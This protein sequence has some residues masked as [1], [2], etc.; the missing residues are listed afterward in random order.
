[1][2]RVLARVNP[3]TSRRAVG[4]RL[5]LVF[6]TLAALGT[7]GSFGQQPVATP[8]EEH[9]AP[10]PLVFQGR[11]ITSF[12]SHLA[13]LSPEERARTARRR[14][15]SLRPP[16][17]DAEVRVVEI[18]DGC[19]LLVGDTLAFSVVAG[20]LDPRLSATPAQEAAAAKAKLVEALHTRAA[21]WSS[22]ARVLGVVYSIVA[23]AL[24]IV[25]V[26]LVVRARRAVLA[27]L[28]ADSGRK[29]RYLALGGFDL[30][31]R[32]SGFLR[33]P[34]MVLSG[35]AV[36]TLIYIWVTFVLNRFPETQPVGHATRGFLLDLFARFGNGCRSALPGLLTAGVVLV[37]ARLATLLLADFFKSVG[38]GTIV[39][40]GLHRETAAATRSLVNAAIWLFA[41]V[42]IYPNLPGSGSA[43]FQGVSVFAG[44]MLTLGSAG[45]VG[46]MMAG[47]VLIYSRA[48]SKGDYVTVGEVE[49]IVTEVGTLSTKIDNR[50]KEEFTIPNAVVVGSA[51]KNFS[52]MNREEGVPLMTSVTIGYGAPWRLVHQMLLAATEKTKGLRRDPAPFVLQRALSDFFVEYELVARLDDPLQRPVV[53][54]ELHQNI[55]DAF[56]E[57]G[58]QIMVP[59]YEG[60]PD[61]PVVVP[62][63][64]WHR[65]GPGPGE[66]A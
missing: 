65:A 35:L 52:R 7:S 26:R 18:A 5:A 42:L 40:R 37:I 22:R 48:L 28:E 25:L 17:L 21:M 1:M 60:Q 27:W 43:A 14:L 4:A 50:R 54:S 15:D 41:V 66:G 3:R 13:G 30:K 49:G 11:T 46:H 59:H 63:S 39:V 6:V 16:Q 45:L 31:T 44:L 61:R 53:L 20:D 34:S 57:Q 36:L 9:Q 62:K 32:L 24:F 58:V 19:T 47:L 29:Q 10:V 33:A 8:P 12:R 2:Q 55:Q 64:A 56:N 51:I 38:N 23:T